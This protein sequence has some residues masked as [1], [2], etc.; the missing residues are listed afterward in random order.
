MKGTPPLI[1]KKRR[2]NHRLLHHFVASRGK[3]GFLG[4]VFKTGAGTQS[5]GKC[6]SQGKRAFPIRSAR[7]RSKHHTPANGEEKD[8]GVGKKKGAKFPLGGEKKK[9]ILRE[10]KDYPRL[11][12]KR[13][14]RKYR[15]PP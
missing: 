7:K 5:E 8:Q 4:R 12:P 11:P 13:P 1:T 3:K 15:T 10:K 6:F 9:R 2:K 14:K